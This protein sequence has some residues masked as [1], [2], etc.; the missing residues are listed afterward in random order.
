V[1]AAGAPA[2]AEIARRRAAVRGTRRWT[3]LRSRL[4]D[5][6]HQVRI[7]LFIHIVDVRECFQTR[8]RLQCLP[9]R[10]RLRA[11]TRVIRGM[12][13]AMDREVGSAL[14]QLDTCDDEQLGDVLVTLVWMALT[15][16][17]KEQQPLLSKLQPCRRQL[18]ENVLTC[19]MREALEHQVEAQDTLDCEL[20]FKVR[21]MPSTTPSEHELTQDGHHGLE[22]GGRRAP[23]NREPGRGRD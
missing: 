3:L 10:L 19:G 22:E 1:S 7:L 9:R 17:V 23:T 14:A 4:A 12:P 21:T 15:R 6:I 13:F 2:T 11:L 18:L 5:A 16:R 8:F 20:W